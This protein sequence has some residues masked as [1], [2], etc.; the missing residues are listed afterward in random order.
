MSREEAPSVVLGTGLLWC[1]VVSCRAGFLED[2]TRWAAV[3]ALCTRIISKEKSFPLPANCSLAGAIEAG[4]VSLF[5]AQ[6]QVFL[7]DSLLAAA[8]HFS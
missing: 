1:V 6:C 4:G 7:Q 3:P 2:R 5:A 8:Q